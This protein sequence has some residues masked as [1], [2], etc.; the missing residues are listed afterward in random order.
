MVNKS[1]R[2][3]TKAEV[4]VAS[5]MAKNGW[6]AAERRKTEGRNDRGDVNPG[7]PKLVIE[8][9]ADKGLQFPEFLRQTEKERV[10]AG[11]NVGVCVIKP[12]GVA[13]KRMHLWWMLMSGG[14]YDALEL[15]ANA[16]ASITGDPGFMAWWYQ[17]EHEPNRRGF[18]T[19]AWFKSAEAYLTMVP[20]TRLKPGLKRISSTGWDM[21][22]LYLPDGLELL[23]LAGLGGEA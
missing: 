1:G 21:R 13:E 8:V 5:Y 14:T 20:G 6:P 11:A 15:V 19:A 17:G 9:K 3:G 18:K 4:Q 22:F 23:R 10:N 2:I 12:P 16:K 7:Q